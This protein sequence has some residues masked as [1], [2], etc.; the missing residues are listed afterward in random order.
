MYTWS[1]DPEEW[2]AAGTSS[3][4]WISRIVRRAE[5]GI[6]QTHPVILLHNQ[7]AGNPATVAALGP[8]IDFYRAHGYAFVDLYGRKGYPA[9]SP[10]GSYDRVTRWPGGLRVDGWVI[11]P[12]TTGSALADLY[13]DGR[14]V[15][16]YRA[17]TYGAALAKAYPRFGGSH[18]LVVTFPFTAGG[19]HQVCA[20]G[21]D[22][23]GAGDD[24]VLG[25][26]SVVV[27]NSPVG[28]LDSAA[29]TPSAVLLSG[30]ALDP[31]TAAAISVVPYVDGHPRA[32]QVANTYRP[33]V[34][35]AH[36]GWGD[37]HGF[38][39]AL[40]VARGTHTVCVDAVNA[41]PGATTRL[42]CAR[43]VT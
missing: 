15:G 41:G 28:Y 4:Y 17:G 39:F 5:A 38:R 33:D 11:D 1:V 9:D 19:A 35:R 2:K 3:S 20:I 24:T 6:T 37:D 14:G 10:F 23:A 26:R 25:C 32:A 13:V 36:P 22:V 34:G 16:R 30:W 21:V 8:I 12:S 31:D 29:G 27:S 42:R 40:P 7:A 43:V 18:G